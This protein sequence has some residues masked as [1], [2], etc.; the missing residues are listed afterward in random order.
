MENKIKFSI[1]RSLLD[2]LYVMIGAFA[3]IEIANIVYAFLDVPH[4]IAWYAVL[5]ATFMLVFLGLGY[6]FRF[7]KFLVLCM[8]IDEVASE[9]FEHD[10]TY[11]E[12]I[13]NATVGFT[14][15]KLLGMLSTSIEESIV[16]PESKLLSNLTELGPIKMLVNA[17][18]FVFR[19]STEFVNVIFVLYLCK[20]QSY[21]E[22]CKYTINFI[23]NGARTFIQV[24][25]T[26]VVVRVF[27][28]VTGFIVSLVLFNRFFAIDL[29]AVI[30]CYA[31]ATG[32]AMFVCDA[33]INPFNVNTI[34][35]KAVDLELKDESIVTEVMNETSFAPIIQKISAI[36]GDEFEQQVNEEETEESEETEKDDSE[37][38]E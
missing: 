35:M 31:F 2:V 32:L 9:Y 14:L 5:L 6:L 17:L 4:V 18:G 30:L 36:G 16:L 27:L 25:Y 22:A 24:V 20:T 21:L 11:G 38:Q 29:Q 23:I 34:L 8:H 28:Q 1:I 7:T 12:V 15:F 37:L 3:T 13:K 33:I 10:P 26:A 19:S